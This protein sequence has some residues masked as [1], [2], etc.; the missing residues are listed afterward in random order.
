MFE[1]P[2]LETCGWAAMAGETPA[3]LPQTNPHTTPMPAKLPQLLLIALALLLP[4]VALRAQESDAWRFVLTD[5]EHNIR[6]G[7]WRITSR[8]LLPDHPQTFSIQQRILRGGRQEGVEVIEIDN[9]VMT[10]TVIPTRGMSILEARRGDLR[11]G[12]E[13]P[14]KEVVHPKYIDHE[15]RGGLGWLE[16]FNEMLVR[17]GLE[18]AG[19]PG[20]DKFITNTGDTAEMDL[21][22][23]GRIGNIPASHVEVLIDRHPPHRIRVRGVVNERMFYGPALELRAELSTVPG[24]SS[25]RVSDE[26]INHGGFD[27]EFQIIYHANFGKP[28]LGENARVIAPVRGI[29]PMNSHAGGGIEDYGRY[30]GPTTGFIEQVYLV[31]PFADEN[32]RSAAVLHNAAGDRAVLLSWNTAQLP[33]LTIWKNTASEA[34]GYVTGIEPGTGFPFNRR[35]ERSFGRVPKL[36]P[37]QS[38]AFDLEFE[39]HVDAESVG[40]AVTKVQMIQG[41]R[42]TTVTREPPRI[43]P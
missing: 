12:W 20:R 6:Q 7:E 34:S 29:A 32:G 37:G 3:P 22:L 17:C 1:S 16:G 9:G 4:T 19:H 38:R 10:I 30:Q 21:T 23:H 33:Y 14:V 27:Q 39:L 8:D 28:L 25:F 36:G 31:E 13:S 35:V 11:L 40:A 2:S 5:A 43:G 18:F 24:E 15:S 42:E 41:S 26:V